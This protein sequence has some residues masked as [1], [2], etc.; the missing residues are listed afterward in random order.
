[1]QYAGSWPGTYLLRRGLHLPYELAGLLNP[2][3]AKEGLRRL[4][5]FRLLSEVLTPDPGSDV[6]RICAL[7][8]SQYMRNQLLRDADWAGMA[9]SIEIRA[10]LV[11]RLVLESLAPAI[12]IL[13]PGK[14]KSALARAP[15]FA[16]PNKVLVRAKTGFNVPTK[17]WMEALANPR[18]D[19]SS[20][21]SDS[22]GFQSKKWSRLVLTNG[23]ITASEARVA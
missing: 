13:V 7:K 23:H 5:P 22:K 21:A 19:R 14:G 17:A 20:F 10:P 15:Q 4:K 9:H 6:G 2:D 12:R 11:D 18:T 16:L 8:S 3:F 1:M